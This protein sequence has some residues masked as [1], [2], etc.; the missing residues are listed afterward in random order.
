MLLVKARQDELTVDKETDFFIKTSLFYL[1]N[2][3]IA[4]ICCCCIPFSD[5]KN[6]K[7]QPDAF[8]P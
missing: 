8:V 3:Y 1:Y 4:C 7:R 2:L 5:Q 6:I